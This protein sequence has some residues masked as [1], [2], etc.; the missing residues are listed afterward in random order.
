MRVTKKTALAMFKEVLAEGE[1]ADIRND[2]IA[3][4]ESW[5]NFIDNLCRDSMITIAQYESWSNPY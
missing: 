2:K 3:M 1:Y 5:S 4:R